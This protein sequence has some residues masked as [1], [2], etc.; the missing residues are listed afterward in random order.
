MEYRPPFSINDNIINK[1]AEISELIGQVS[2]LHK[3][4]MS[5]RLRRE[6]RIKTIHSSLAIE[7]N[8]LSLEQ[9]TA[10]LNGKRVLGAPQEIKEVQNAYEAYEAMLRLDPMNIEDMLCAHKLM[11]NELLK[12]SGRFRNGDVGIWEGEKLIHAAPPAHLVPE[13]ISNLFA[14]YKCSGLHILIKSCIFHYE[15]EFIHPFS[16]G[17]G[18]MGRMWHTLLLTQWNELFAWLPIEE[19][20]RERQKEYYD[21][22]ALSD[23][24]ADCSGFV[25]IMLGIIFDALIRLD[26]TDQES[27]Q[28][29]DQVKRL[30]NVLGDEELSASELME[31]LNL[32]H[33]PTFRKNYLHPALDKNLIE[34]TVPGKPNSRNQKYRKVY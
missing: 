21:A 15:F 7:H 10:V 13:L 16:D 24:A 33:K 6:N 30:M 3:D 20:I 25:E 12:E 26:R 22:L 19:L 31:R 9:V 11:T 8:S 18:R 14:W 32:S 2:V 1:L 34:M 29:S 28:E 27:D 4:R 5:P 23:K 17:N